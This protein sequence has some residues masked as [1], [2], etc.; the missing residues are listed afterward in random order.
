M[1]EKEKKNIVPAVHGRRIAQV[2]RGRGGDLEDFA[3]TS[4]SVVEWMAL[5]EQ[6]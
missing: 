2:G 6:S 3:A 1:G 5:K 4:G